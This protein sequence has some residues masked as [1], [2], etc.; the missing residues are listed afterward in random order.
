MVVDVKDFKEEMHAPTRFAIVTDSEIDEFVTN[1]ENLNT[2]KNTVWAMRVFEHWRNEK[3]CGI[4]E[5]VE[6]TSEQLNFQCIILS[7]VWYPKEIIVQMVYITVL[8]SPHR[9]LFYSVA[10][11]LV[12]LHLTSALFY[13]RMGGAK[14]NRMVA[15]SFCCFPTS[16]PIGR[17]LCL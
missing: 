1:N 16:V 17:K 9:K 14:L 7:S 8:T 12:Q 3:N 2:K 11:P 13:N 4:P 6:M 10:P 15:I 5:L